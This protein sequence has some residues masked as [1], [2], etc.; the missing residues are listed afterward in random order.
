MFW[1]DSTQALRRELLTKFGIGLN[2]L[3]RTSFVMLMSL[4]SDLNSVC[5][6]FVRNFL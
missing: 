2:A 6:Q 3:E 4:S 5:S 1:S